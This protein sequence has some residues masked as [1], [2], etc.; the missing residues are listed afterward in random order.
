M[1]DCKKVCM[2]TLSISS[3]IFIY[4]TQQLYFSQLDVRRSLKQLK[5]FLTKISPTLLIVKG[6]QTYFWYKENISIKILIL[7]TP[8][9]C[10]TNF[11]YPHIIFLSHILMHSPIIHIASLFNLEVNL[12]FGFFI[13]STAMSADISHVMGDRRHHHRWGEV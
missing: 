11:L 1:C 9:I 3:S 5:P 4:Q 13:F 10:Y 6:V 8:L 2:F 7:F 12:I